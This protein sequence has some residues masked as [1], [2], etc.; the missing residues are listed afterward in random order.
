[1]SKNP[2]QDGHIHEVSRWI[3]STQTEMIAH[4][5]YKKGLLFSLEREDSRRILVPVHS[6]EDLRGVEFPVFQCAYCK[7]KYIV[8]PM[9]NGRGLFGL[10]LELGKPEWQPVLP[11]ILPSGGWLHVFLGKHF[12]NHTYSS[13]SLCTWYQLPIFQYTLKKPLQVVWSI[14]SFVTEIS[15]DK[16]A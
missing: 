12:L 10:V 4:E 16:I 5:T 3:F 7:F 9:D 13:I 6:C 1:M 2:A 14:A 15:E 11:K 8:I